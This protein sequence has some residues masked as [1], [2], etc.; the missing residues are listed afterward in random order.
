MRNRMNLITVVG[1]VAGI[2]MF[3]GISLNAMADVTIEETND[4]AGFAGMGASKGSSTILIQGVKQ[5]EESRMEFTGAIMSKLAGSQRNITI[6]RVDKGVYWDLDT[7]NKTYKERPI[8]LPKE[9]PAKPEPKEKREKAEKPEK[10]KVR[11]TKNEFTV[12]KTGA[13]KEIN[14]FPCEE[15]IA[16]WLLETENLETKEKSTSRMV[17]TLWTTPETASIM[18]AK[19]EREAFNHALMEKMGLKVSP[20]ESRRMGLSM[21]TGMVGANEAEMREGMIKFSK[22][23]SK[24]KGYPIV[25]RVQWFVEGEEGKSQAKEK[26]GEPESSSPGVSGGLGSFLSGLAGKAAE[27]KAKERQEAQAG[28]PG[29]DMTIEIKSIKA[30]TISQSSFEIPEGYTKR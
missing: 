25:T 2:W 8:A 9:K 29:I 1:I 11:I 20:D 14:G 10:Q 16:A 27:K 30:D 7:K 6:T 23:L 22:E 19:K 26:S 4:S 18:H 28:K 24:I 15:Y 5:M 21:A 17:N 13:S 12:K 3:T